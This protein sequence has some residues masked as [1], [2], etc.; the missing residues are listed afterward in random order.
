MK[1]DSG[2]VDLKLSSCLLTNV[3]ICE[4]TQKDR[5][6]VVIHNPLSRVVSHYVHLPVEGDSYKITGPDGDELYDIFDTIHSFDYV[7]ESVKPASRELVFVARDLPALGIKVYYVEKTTQ[8]SEYKPFKELTDEDDG[9]FGTESNGFTVDPKTGKLA[10][11]TINGAKQDISQEFL[12]YPSYTDGT[13]GDHRSSGAYIF[14]P[15]ANVATPMTTQPFESI[16]FV[17]G[18]LVDELIQVINPEVTQIIRSYKATEEPYVE[19][20]WLVGDIQM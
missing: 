11:V 10:T 8:E 2:E 9:K 17:K 4:T 12:Y 15:A 7:K 14:R 20:D 18:N 13:S 6:L 5:F 16:K 19:F 1:K 3:S